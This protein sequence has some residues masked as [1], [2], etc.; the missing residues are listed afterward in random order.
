MIHVEP[1]KPDRTDSRTN[2]SPYAAA[3]TND[4]SKPK[5]RLPADTLHEGHFHSVDAAALHNHSPELGVEPHQPTAKGNEVDLL[6]LDRDYGSDPDATTTVDADNNTDFVSAVQT[7]LTDSLSKSGASSVADASANDSNKDF[8]SALQ[9]ALPDSLSKRAEVESQQ[10]TATGSDAEQLELDCDNDDKNDDMSYGDDQP[11]FVEY[12]QVEPGVS[13]Q[14]SFVEYGEVEPG[15]SDQPSFV[16]HD[17]VEPG[18]S[19]QPSFVEYD[20]VEPGVGTESLFNHD[21][22]SRHGETDSTNDDESDEHVAGISSDDLDDIMGDSLTDSTPGTPHETDDLPPRLSAS[23]APL[24]H[25]FTA[26]D[27][28]KPAAFRTVGRSVGCSYLSLVSDNAK[29]CCGCVFTFRA[30]ALSGSSELQI[31]RV[32]YGWA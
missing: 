3:A 24:E 17:Q 9:T 2:A 31:S 32:A 11:S 27:I 4:E 13:D 19:D 8:A 25:Q 28:G 1:A 12:G 16:E 21:G 29:Q 14:P 15:V 30:L 22:S 18:V 20:Q 10:P 23:G 6:E 5:P 26:A 7:T